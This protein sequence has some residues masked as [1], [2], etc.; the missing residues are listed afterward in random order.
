MRR[1]RARAS[2][3]EAWRETGEGGGGAADGGHG[4]S[5]TGLAAIAGVLTHAPALA[6]GASL[7]S[8]AFAITIARS[9]PF[10]ACH[11]T[12]AE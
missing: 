4:L 11:A 1:S 9:P 12:A 3:S 2:V 6:A 8:A 10:A 7:A 5:R